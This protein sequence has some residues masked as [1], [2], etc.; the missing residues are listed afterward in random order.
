VTSYYVRFLI[1]SDNVAYYGPQEGPFASVEEATEHAERVLAGQGFTPS[2]GET[3]VRDY[4]I[5]EE[6]EF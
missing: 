3:G 1:G 5:E 6:E 2:P 4:V